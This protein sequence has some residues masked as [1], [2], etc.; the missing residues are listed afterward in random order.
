M[1]PPKGGAPAQSLCFPHQFSLLS[2]AKLKLTWSVFLDSAF[3][4]PVPL[5]LPAREEHVDSHVW[6]E[7]GRF[8]Y[9]HHILDYLEYQETNQPIPPIQRA[10]INGL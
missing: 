10:F 1:P 5:G 2:S 4:C 3:K 7:W 6:R 9:Q 8:G